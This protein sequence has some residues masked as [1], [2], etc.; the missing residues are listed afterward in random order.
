MQVVECFKGIS[1]KLF[2]FGLKPFDIVLTL[3][4]F[5]FVHGFINSLVV[6]VI[7]VVAAYLLAKN[8]RNRPD[9]VLLSLYLYFS[10]PPCLPV[11]TDRERVKTE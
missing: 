1:H 8:M 3:V 4:G 11:P 10:T 7:Y 2:V 9:N 6:D 5:M